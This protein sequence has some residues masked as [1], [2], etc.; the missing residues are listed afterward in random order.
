MDVDFNGFVKGLVNSAVRD[1]VTV[2]H[3]DWGGLTTTQ[4]EVEF[5]Q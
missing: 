4:R 2:K 3:V 5:F 1:E